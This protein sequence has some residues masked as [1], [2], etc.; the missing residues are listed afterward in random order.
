MSVKAEP[1]KMYSKRNSLCVCD[2]EVP[3]EHRVDVVVGDI[4]E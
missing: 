4:K 1:M 2:A 3:D